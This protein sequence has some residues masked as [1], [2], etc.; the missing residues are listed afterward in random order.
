MDAEQPLREYIVQKHH[1][2][3]QRNWDLFYKRNT[4]NFFKVWT[5]FSDVAPTCMAPLVQL[6]CWLTPLS[7]YACCVLHVVCVRAR[8][9]ARVCVCVCVVWFEGSRTGIGY[10]GSS[11]RSRQPRQ[12]VAPPPVVLASLPPPPPPLLPRK[13]LQLVTT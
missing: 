10:R 7:A 1:K 4:T 13:A 5:P 12:I 6:S 3:A 8:A 9:R 2:E 11:Q